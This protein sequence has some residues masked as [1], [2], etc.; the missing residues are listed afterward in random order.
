TLK[1]NGIEHIPKKCPVLLLCN[2]PSSFTEPMLLACHQHRILNFLVRGDLFEN[3]FLKP[4]LEATYQIPIYRA[5]DGFENLRKNKSTFQIVYNK[6]V[7]QECVLIFPESTT[8]LVRYLRPIQKGA[9]LMAITSVQEYNLIDLVVVPCGVNF[10]NILKAGSDAVINFGTPININEWLKN[11]ENEIDLPNKLTELF[12]N[13]MNKVIF[14]VPSTLSPEFYDQIS[15]MYNEKEDSSS[16]LLAKHRNIINALHY[17]KETLESLVLA[18]SNPMSDVEAVNHAIL[19]S[20]SY[21]FF[22]ILRSFLNF[23][24]GIP[25]LFL[26]GTLL[27]L[28][29]TLAFKMVKKEFVPPIRILFSVVGIFIVTVILAILI[30]IHFGI[31]IGLLSSL[32]SI[33]SMLFLLRFIYE[34]K[35]NK[36]LFSIN[37]SKRKKELI[38]TRNQIIELLNSFA[39]KA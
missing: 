27:L 20:S 19:D 37:M 39:S 18:Y 28:S 11:H 13:E 10:T 25:S 36:Y 29:R 32:A 17:K 16:T 31:V 7:D 8:Q 9:A 30:S 38:A 6:L 5:R 12:T 26:H 14:S 35:E 34:A 3:K 2:H 23:I 1:V 15:S 4:I 22:Q 21:K 33:V 24:L